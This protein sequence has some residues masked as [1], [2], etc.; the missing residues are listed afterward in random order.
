MTELLCPRA[1]VRLRRRAHAQAGAGRAA[2]A[3]DDHRVVGH[4]D[5]L[6]LAPRSPHLVAL[7]DRQVAQRLGATDPRRIEAVDREEAGVVRDRRAGVDEH[8]PEALGRERGG[9]PRVAFDPL[10]ERGLVPRP[11]ASSN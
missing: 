6:E 8:R 5:G 4:G 10:A 9:G 3:G 1:R 7:E 11:G 2:R